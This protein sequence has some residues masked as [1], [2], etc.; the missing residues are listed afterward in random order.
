MRCEECP[1]ISTFSLAGAGDPNYCTVLK[2]QVKRGCPV[3]P[4]LLSSRSGKWV[5]K[6][7]AC[8]EEIKAKTKSELRKMWENHSCFQKFVRDGV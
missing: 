4:E 2:K 7:R 3:P 6:C 5:L 1:F 8:G